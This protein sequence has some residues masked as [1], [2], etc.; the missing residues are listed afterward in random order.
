[1][2]VEFKSL[3]DLDTLVKIAGDNMAMAR[4]AL[5]VTFNPTESPAKAASPTPRTR[6]SK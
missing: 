1:V 4:F 6:T 2:K 5:S 3:E